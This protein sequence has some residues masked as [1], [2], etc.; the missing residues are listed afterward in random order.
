LNY[1]YGDDLRQEMVAE[2][3]VYTGVESTWQNQAGVFKPNSITNG[4][5]VKE[6]S[7]MN[8]ARMPLGV[9]TLIQSNL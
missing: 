5:A 6:I 7:P 1:Y 4:L 3:S 8:F 2:I 9:K